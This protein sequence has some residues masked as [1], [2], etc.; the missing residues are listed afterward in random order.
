[1]AEVVDGL[2]WTRSKPDLRMYREMFGMSTAEFGRL[3]A[4]DGRTVRAWENPRE[5]VPDRTAWM[6]AESLWRDA[7]RMASG[8]VPEAG[9]GPVVLPYGSGASTPA[10][11]ASRIAAGRLSAAG[12]PW[13]ASF[14]RPDG[15]DCGKARFR[16]MTDMLHLG[17]EK[18]SVL[19]GVTRQTV[20]AWRHPRMRD[21]VPSPAAFDAVGERWDIDPPAV[22]RCRN[23]LQGEAGKFRADEDL[24]RRPLALGQ[25]GCLQADSG[26]L[27][28]GG[29]WRRFRCLRCRLGRRRRIPGRRFAVA[30]NADLLRVDFLQVGRFVAHLAAEQA[31][32][33]RVEQEVGKNEQENQDAHHPASVQMLQGEM[34]QRFDD[35]FGRVLV[36]FQLA[37]EKFVVGRHVEMAVAGQAE[38]DGFFLA[39]GLAAQG[40]VDGCTDG[41]A[42]L[43]GGDDAFGTSKL[44]ASLESADLRHGDRLQLLFV[45]QLRDQGRGAVVAQTAGMDAGGHE[46]VPEGVHLHDRRVAG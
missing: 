41:V 5:W 7:E 1:M 8:L 31:V 6:A 30:E 29:H 2:T 38:E 27:L 3:A 25:R 18:G 28:A 42:G 40:F 17:G 11:V 19:F 24:Q 13:D 16:L 21:S 45:E 33:K 34:L 9:E 39:S 20:F 4:V 12:R 22:R 23:F 36:I 26:L 32:A 14:P 43:G 35:G 15:P 37:A 10:C 46:I 44:H